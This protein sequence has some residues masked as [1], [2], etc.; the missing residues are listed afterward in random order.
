MVLVV[1]GATVDVVVDV[2]DVDVEVVDV[3]VVD[4]V[5]W[6]DAALGTSAMTAR[7][8][9]RNDLCSRLMFPP[10]LGEFAETVRRVLP[11]GHRRR[12]G[13]LVQVGAAPARRPASPAHR[14]GAQQYGVMEH[15]GAHEHPER[16]NGALPHRLR[17][18]EGVGARCR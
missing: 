5:V 1:V 11:A 9:T 12:R 15:L 6:A 16:L 8:I 4:V 7:R 3:D 14:Q 18:A 13:F 10:S 17:L 2:V